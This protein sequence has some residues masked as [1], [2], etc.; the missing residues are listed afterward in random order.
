MD[1][2]NTTL[3]GRLPLL[4]PK[5]LEGDQKKLYALLDSTLISWADASGFKGKTDDGKLI[6]PFNPFLY[7]TGIT[8]GFLQWMQAESKHT[9]LDKRVH[10]VVILSTGAVRQSPYEL[11]AHSAVAR[12]AGVPEAAIHWPNGSCRYGLPDRDVSSHVCFVECVQNTR[13]GVTDGS[14]PPERFA[15]SNCLNRHILTPYD[16]SRSGSPRP[17][18]SH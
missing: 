14:C 4:D 5:D 11:Y 3:G 12:E 18:D 16:V 7:S 13:T 8:P 2:N 17:M 10:E 6:G 1:D 15:T 9:S